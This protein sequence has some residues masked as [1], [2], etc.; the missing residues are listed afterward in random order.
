[1]LATFP[2]SAPRV[3]WRI[4]L[5]L[6]LLVALVGAQEDHD[7]HDHGEEGK[8][9]EWAGSF[10]MVRGVHTLTLSKVGGEYADA[11][12]LITLLPVADATAGVEASEEKFDAM[13]KHAGH[14]G[15]EHDDH[16]DDDHDDHEE[17]PCPKG[18]TTQGMSI[19]LLEHDGEVEPGVYKLAVDDDSA[20]TL[21]K[22]N[23]TR[24]GRYVLAAEHHMLEFENGKHF[25]QGPDGEDL[26]PVDDLPGC[27]DS[28]LPTDQAWGFSILG[29]LI[30]QILT[31]LAAVGLVYPLLTR[32]DM[33]TIRT[34]MGYLS[35]FAVGILVG[36]VF[37]HLIP[38][39]A[40]LAGGL[41]WELNTLIVAGFFTGLLIEFTLHPSHAD[42]LVASAVEREVEARRAEPQV[43]PGLQPPVAQNGSF[44]QYQL[45]HPFPVPPGGAPTIPVPLGAAP[46]KHSRGIAAEEAQVERSEG[47]GSAASSS[48]YSTLLQPIVVNILVGDFFHNLFDGIAIASAFRAC[49]D[50]G[51]IVT[52]SVVLH[53][54]PQELSDFCI[55]VRAGLT[56]P[57]ALVANLVSAASTF[58]GVIIAMSISSDA[59][60]GASLNLTT[61]RM[62]GFASGILLYVATE[63]MK[64]VVRP[65]DVAMRAGL[66]LCLSVGMVVIGILGLFHIHCESCNAAHDHG[67]HDGHSH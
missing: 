37:L 66:L 26:E 62:L 67:E 19:N 18:L 44:P 49:G 45:G 35:A 56:M 1:M 29:S 14:C 36:L 27:Q 43:K 38:E 11:T 33:N 9:Y 52:A 46:Q 15:E 41:G 58:I 55:L 12:M 17:M 59:D 23:I 7:G 2:L 31:I 42:E 8:N 39:A 60:T 30:G 48:Q 34:S 5:A 13:L 25:L 61:G 20:T 47:K 65:K 22:I 64:R 28:G 57:V 53:E 24:A 6:L 40:A 16:D 50:L 3:I 32:G 54:L 51:W 21:F 4:F 63:V 10:D